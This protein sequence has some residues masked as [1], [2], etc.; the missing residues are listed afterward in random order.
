MSVREAADQPVARRF[1]DRLTEAAL[2]GL[3]LGLLA[4]LG[5]ELLRIGFALHFEVI[6]T[7]L[8]WLAFMLF[9]PVA[10]TIRHQR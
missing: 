6:G 4:A 9:L 3:L 10:L 5:I 2:G 1:S 7:A 8:I